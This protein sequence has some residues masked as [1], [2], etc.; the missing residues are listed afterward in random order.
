MVD[1]RRVLVTGAGGPAGITVVQALRQ[2]GVWVLGGDINRY[3]AGLQ[4]AD[5]A[6]V[7]PRYSS[8]GY[9][10]SLVELA[11]QHGVNGVI[12]TMTEGLS[13]LTEPG[14]EDVFA[15]AG[16]ATWFPPK[17]AVDACLDKAKFAEVTEGAGQPVPRSAWGEV[18]DT[19][20]AVPG[21]WI[22]KP[23]F[24]RGSRDI[25]PAD[26]ADYVREVWPR[27]P[28]PILQTRISGREF[29][30]DALVDRDGNLVG[31]V[32]RF[33]LETKA[34]ISTTGVTFAAEGL[35]DA[36]EGFLGSL[37][38]RGPANVQGFLGEAGELT[39]MEVNPRFSGALALSLG[40]GCDL[41]G[42]Y[43]NHMYG[44]PIDTSAL[45]YEPGT[46]MVRYWKEAFFTEEPPAIPPIRPVIPTA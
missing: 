38:H 22:V 3:G 21:P 10:E 17:A 34:G 18:D 16:I 31:G 46:V 4:L 23:R 36:V 15:A 7:I 14:T 35:F 27:V 26:E 2:A 30:F 20:A 9:A 29:T 5:E 24:G 13:V 25:Y 8:P 32:P 6:A 41:V 28:E 44:E 45:S 1:P 39:F 42:Q 40:A 11:Q 19:L 37:G 33:R 12:S 43:V